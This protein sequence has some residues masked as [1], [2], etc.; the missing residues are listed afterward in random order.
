MCRSNNHI[1][2]LL[3][4]IFWIV[5]FHS[6]PMIENAEASKCSVVK[7][8]QAHTWLPTKSKQLK[9]LMEDFWS[10]TYSPDVVPNAHLVFTS[11]TEVHLND[12]RKLK[13]RKPRC[14]NCLKSQA[15]EFYVKGLKNFTLQYQKCLEQ[16]G[17]YLQ[18]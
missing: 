3:W 15:V 11:R 16:N 5:P 18:K 1:T 17:N 9:I 10:S 12:S 13:S 8:T 2:S 14:K 4:N 6:E 7:I